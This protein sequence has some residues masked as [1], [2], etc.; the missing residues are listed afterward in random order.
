MNTED[1]EDDFYELFE[2]VPP[3]F[4]E[5]CG[6][7]ESSFGLEGDPMT[8]KMCTIPL[9]A[10][11]VRY[12]NE[13]L[14]HARQLHRSGDVEAAWYH[15]GCAKAAVAER[16]GFMEGRYQSSDAAGA[17]RVAAHYG[18]QGSQKKKA[19]N[20]ERREAFAD[21][22][23]A[24]HKEEPFKIQRQLKA[25][26]AK[27]GPGGGDKVSDDAWGLRLIKETRLSDLYQSLSR[28]RK[29]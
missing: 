29:P 19:I 12:V 21:L 17:T 7:V 4:S 27:L 15:Y 23:L 2:L 10:R 14:D 3:T 5:A 13:T 16:N 24:Q 6:Q 8:E 18:R 25:A 11:Q 26:A 9:T 28:R 22:L 1:K 20:K